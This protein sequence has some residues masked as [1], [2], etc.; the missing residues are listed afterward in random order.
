MHSLAFQMYGLWTNMG[1]WL[2]MHSLPSQGILCTLKF[3]TLWSVV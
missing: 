3:E 1:G 2:E